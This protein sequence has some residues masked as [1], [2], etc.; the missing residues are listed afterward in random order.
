MPYSLTL[1]LHLTAE[2]WKSFEKK[3]RVKPTVIR[4]HDGSGIFKTVDLELAEITLTFY[5]PTFYE[6]ETSFTGKPE[7]RVGAK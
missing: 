3:V 7:D 5:S 4:R 1:N 2:E 6:A